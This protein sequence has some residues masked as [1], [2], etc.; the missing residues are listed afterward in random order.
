MID[1]QN[2]NYQFSSEGQLNIPRKDYQMS[3]S[4]RE[5]LHPS[6]K[7]IG[8]P[9]TTAMN[10]RF[11]SLSSRVIDLWFDD[12]SGGTPQGTLRPG[13]D[14]TTNAYEGHVFFYTPKGKKSEILG[15]FTMKKNQV[16]GKTIKCLDAW[17][18]RW[19][20]YN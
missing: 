13:Q 15:K 4:Y 16:I 10:A 6:V 18:D 7:F 9:P 5:V 12:G 19:M 8:G 2:T 17:M 14:T 20:Y 11:R 3:S 1:G